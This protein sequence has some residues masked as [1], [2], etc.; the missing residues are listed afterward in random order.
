MPK[1]TKKA[2]KTIG[3]TRKTARAGTVLEDLASEMAKAGHK[4][5]VKGDDE[6]KITFQ[7]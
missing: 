6:V 7:R 3:N 4:V 1:A 2:T 5:T